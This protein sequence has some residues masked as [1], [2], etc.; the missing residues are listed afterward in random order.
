M[1]GRIVE[2]FRQV[3]HQQQLNRMIAH[4]HANAIIGDRFTCQLS[5]QITNESRDRSRIS[6]GH[7]CRL[8]GGLVVTGGGRIEVGNYT[9]IQHYTYLRCV[10]HITIGS[11]CGIA[12]NALI[13]DNNTH[14]T[15][16]ESW[17]E[18]RIRMAPD[19]QGYPGL[20]YGW[21][22]AESAPVVIGDGVWIG[23]NSTVLKGVTIGDGAIVARGAIVTKDVEP[24][25]LV[26]GNP[27]RVVKQLPRPDLSVAELAQRILSG[28][29]GRG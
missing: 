3:R 29:G 27:A 19:G 13:I 7:H 5:T 26:A 22:L 25:T 20:G 17:I 21:E 10:N 8:N 28:S 16:I 18:H 4:C 2:K 9:T 12:S 1:V 23:G 14:R 6:L 15:D 24:F 11:F